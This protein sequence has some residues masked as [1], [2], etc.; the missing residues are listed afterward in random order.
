[1]YEALRV[2]EVGGSEHGLALLP[3]LLS[4]S[5]VDVVWCVEPQG[6]FQRS[7]IDLMSRGYAI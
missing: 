7:W 6:S 2:R 3:T 4:L 5:V 1:M